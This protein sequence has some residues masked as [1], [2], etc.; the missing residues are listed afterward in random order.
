MPK[1]K[2][3]FEDKLDQLEQIVDE[4]KQNDNMQNAFAKY[5]Q[6]IKLVKECQTELDKFEKKITN[7]D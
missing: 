2:K 1:K 6:G 4:L 7:L 3:S 5:K